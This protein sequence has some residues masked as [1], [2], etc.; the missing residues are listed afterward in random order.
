MNALTPVLSIRD[1]VVEFPFREDTFR[2]VD[3]VSFEIM[4]GEV[5]GVVGESGAGKSMTGAAVIGLIE[6]PGR[7]AA[8][9]VV[10]Q[11]TV[12]PPG[13]VMAGVPASRSHT[14][15]H[16]NDRRMRSLPRLPALHP[17]WR[18]A[19]G[20][21]RTVRTAAATLRPLRAGD[22]QRQGGAGANAT[23][24]GCETAHMP[25]SPSGALSMPR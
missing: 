8:G 24:W 21:L 5:L 7:I 3:G 19:A 22:K 11:G 2:A 25:K 17:A 15:G 6:R 16:R 4:P 23:I 12:V 14:A 9:A 13:S 10:T 20:S 18:D 1:L